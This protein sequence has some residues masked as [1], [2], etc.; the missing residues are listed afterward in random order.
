MEKAE[1]WNEKMKN[2]KKSENSTKLQKILNI[3]KKVLIP[4]IIQKRISKP[5]LIE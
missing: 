3:N 1:K 2:F 5:I 4:K